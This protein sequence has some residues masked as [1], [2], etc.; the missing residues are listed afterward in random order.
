METIAYPILIL[1][2][3][4]QITATV[5]ALRLVWTTGKIW[6]WLFV[7]TGITLMAARRGFTLY[8]CVTQGLPPTVS[9]EIIALISSSFLLLGLSLIGPLFVGLKRRSEESLMQSEEKYRLLAKTAPAVVFQGYIDGTIDL[10]DDKMTEIVGYD[11]ELFISRKLKW[12]DL[13]FPQD[14]EAAKTAFIQALKGNGF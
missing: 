9:T 13:I 5:L 2:M 3:L 6:A 7:A 14:Q 8:H 11:K 10:F 12:T 1:S 4:V